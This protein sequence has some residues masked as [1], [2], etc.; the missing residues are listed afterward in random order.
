MTHLTLASDFAPSNPVSSPHSYEM[1]TRPVP[2][3]EPQSAYA[4]SVLVRRFQK[5]AKRNSF[6][7]VGLPMMASVVA[8]SFL[9]ASFQEVR[10]E[11]RDEKFKQHRNEE[12]L[13]I[14]THGRIK[15]KEHAVSLEDELK[16]GL[17]GSSY[18][19]I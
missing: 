2:S 15:K 14:K 11:I 17:R 16:V 5:L 18:V 19:Y 3:R 6:L 8:G 4:P 7:Y 12:E 10:M 9:L 13:G 1:S